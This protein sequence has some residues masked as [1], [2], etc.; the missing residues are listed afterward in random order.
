[1]NMGIKDAFNLG[2]KLAL[3]ARDQAAPGL[4][5]T[6]E[7]ERHPIARGVLQG[8]HLGTRLFLAQNPLMR[9]VREQAVPAIVNI[10]PV[11]RRILAAVS[12]LAVGYRGSPSPSMSMTGKRLA[13]GCVAMVEG[14]DPATGSRMPHSSTP[15][16]VRRWRSST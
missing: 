12:Q 11:R 8:T 2:W 16:A 3:A 1:M 10:P 15:A 13:A 5:N 14:F 6:Y 7:S 9:A 4:L